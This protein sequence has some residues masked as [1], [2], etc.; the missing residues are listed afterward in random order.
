[1]T[2]NILKNINFKKTVSVLQYQRKR[3]RPKNDSMESIFFKW[4][5]AGIG[6][7]LRNNRILCED[8]SIKMLAV[9]KYEK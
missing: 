4:K 2:L 6:L 3:L 7:T 1:M 8:S 9:K 5:M